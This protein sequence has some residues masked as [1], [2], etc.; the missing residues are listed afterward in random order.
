MQLLKLIDGKRTYIIVGVIVL[1]GTL[2]EL[3]IYEISQSGWI[4]LGAFGLGFLRAGV[5]KWA[6]VIKKL[7]PLIEEIKKEA[8]K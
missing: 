7:M 3:G 8:K 2:Q 5:N 6:S 1:L 4:I